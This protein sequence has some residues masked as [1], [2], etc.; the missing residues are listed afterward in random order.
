MLPLQRAARDWCGGGEFT[1]VAGSGALPKAPYRCWILG[2][3]GCR[4]G[5]VRNG[6]AEILPCPRG[7]RAVV[8]R[9]I[10]PSRDGRMP[11]GSWVWSVSGLGHAQ[12]ARSI[13]ANYGCSLSEEPARFRLGGAPDRLC[14]ELHRCW[15][16]MNPSTEMFGQVIAPATSRRCCRVLHD[17]KS[18]ILEYAHTRPMGSGLCAREQVFRFF[19]SGIIAKWPPGAFLNIPPI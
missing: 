17:C 14:M 5:V 15:R 1:V 7:G 9:L 13:L 12:V 8:A 10:A 19:A 16:R 11:Q 4:G 18:C 6:G 3:V 2:C